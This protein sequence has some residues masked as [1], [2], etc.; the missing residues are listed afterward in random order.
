[1]L[2]FFVMIQFI[3]YLHCQYSKVPRY[4]YSK[5]IV[6]LCY[7]CSYTNH[8]VNI[9]LL[10]QISEKWR[11]IRDALKKPTK[12]QINCQKP[13]AVLLDTGEMFDT[14]PWGVMYC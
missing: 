13:K 5:F 9:I 4:Q 6:P 7:L 8:K 3:G 12:E 2:I 11:K 14:I 1:M 10:Y